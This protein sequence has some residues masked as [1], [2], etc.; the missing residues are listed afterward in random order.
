[1]ANQLY[2]IKNGLAGI[3]GSALSVVMTFV[4]SAD[5]WLRLV[6]SMLGIVVAGLTI[7]NLIRNLKK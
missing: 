7:C 6:G 2:I 1:M 4:E 3:S 5:L